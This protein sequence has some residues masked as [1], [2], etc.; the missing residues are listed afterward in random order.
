MDCP[1][2]GESMEFRPSDDDN[3]YDYGIKEY[4]CDSCNIKVTVEP[5]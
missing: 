1:E 4:E 2:C 5:K 3:Y